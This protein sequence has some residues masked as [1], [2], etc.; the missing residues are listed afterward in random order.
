ML[1]R[2]FY[3]FIEG[4]NKRLIDEHEIARRQAY[5]M[6]APHLSKPMTIGQFYKEYWPLPDDKIEENTRQK[7]LLDKLKRLKENGSRATTDTSTG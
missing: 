5:F 3:Q 2:D 6:L 1:P 7:R 4:Y